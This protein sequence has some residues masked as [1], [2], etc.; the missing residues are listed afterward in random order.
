MTCGRA[1][2][3]PRDRSIEVGYIDN[4]VAANLLFRFRIWAIQH[5]QLAI[6]DPHGRCV[7]TR[8]EAVAA[9]EDAGFCQSLTFGA[10]FS[11]NSATKKLPGTEANSSTSDERLEMHLDGKLKITRVSSAS[12]CSKR[13]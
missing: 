13:R 1:T 3:R 4:K 8:L 5:L 9:L 10:R 12:D 2:P 7:R 11:I 6:R